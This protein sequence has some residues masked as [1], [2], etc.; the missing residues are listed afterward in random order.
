MRESAGL[1][2]IPS[3]FVS[4]PFA[5][6]GAVA[7]LL[8][9]AVAALQVVPRPLERRAPT[10][11]A[12]VPEPSPPVLLPEATR[13]SAEATHRAEVQTP[14]AG[15]APANAVLRGRCVAAETGKALAGC[16]V[17]FHGGG[18][19][20]PAWTAL[21]GPIS[22]TDPAP[23]RTG[24]DGRFQFS[25]V[26][27]PPFGDFVLSV[28][29]EGRAP[30]TGRWFEFP[31]GEVRDLGDVLMSRGWRVRGHVVDTD[32]S[33]ADGVSVGFDKLPLP[34][35]GSKAA[36]QARYGGTGPDG[37]FEV[38]ALLPA[39]TFV[40]SIPRGAFRLVEPRIATIEE[41]KG[42]ENLRVVVRR[43]PTIEGRVL[44]EEEKGMEGVP[45]ALVAA[46]ATEAAARTSRSF[47][48]GKTGVDGRFKLRPMYGADGDPLPRRLTV[49]ASS[50]FEVV[51]EEPEVRWGTK[52]ARLVARRVREARPTLALTVVEAGSG[53]PVEEFAVRCHPEDSGMAAE[54]SWRLGG[55]HEGGAVE[56]DGISPGRH[57]L[58]VVPREPTL[59]PTL[60]L[61]FEVPASGPVPP[62]RVEVERAR[63]FVVHVRTRSGVPLGGSEVHLLRPQPPRP[64]PVD[65]E[66]LF[67][68][69]REA[70]IPPWTS[71]G[72]FPWLLSEA[73]TGTDGR[74]Q[75]SGPP[76]AKGLVLR[77]TG[78]SHPPVIRND[79]VV[80]EADATVEIIPPEPSRL[81]GRVKPNGLA[82]RAALRV[83][84]AGERGSLPDPIPIATDGAFSIA[85]LPAGLWELRFVV[86]ME[87][88][89]S[90]GPG[91]SIHTVG[92]IDCGKPLGVFRLE[93]GETKEVELD[94]TAL[95]TGR[96]EGKVVPSEILRRLPKARLSGKTGSMEG[97]AGDYLLDA[98]GRFTVPDAL[99]GEYTISLVFPDGEALESPEGFKIGAGE[100]VV[101]EFRFMPR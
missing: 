47:T 26:P 86:R 69:F 28:S 99:P 88:D 8:A 43:L 65:A 44:D 79:L 74:A 51:G 11:V 17:E 52:D 21:N 83:K 55:R 16:L 75:I 40:V 27:P 22:W 62:L 39:G 38:R 9:A 87:R 42:I 34:V 37:A 68:R 23:V 18:G 92:W 97:H 1:A 31:P 33:P 50:G 89:A 66:T 80:P 24:A 19:N 54:A 6:L 20:V 60:P 59:V 57:V 84:R 61:E 2:R 63:P 94:A 15:S 53:R 67:V 49:A 36:N 85:S 93:E 35:E 90:H 48:F 76:G 41:G 82:D 12:A 98:E 46:G 30:R 7:C 4:H 64:V 78:S 56:V 58:V 71:D 77:V 91:A 10:L 14:P 101:R 73:R 45:L 25:F 70:R 3:T 13:E 81:W 72:S 29:A 5:S 32:G 95:V 96:L 100:R